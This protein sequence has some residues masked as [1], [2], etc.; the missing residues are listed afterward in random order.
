MARKAHLTSTIVL[1]AALGC[2]A[3][4]APKT[5]AA[6]QSE[7]TFDA[8]L[9]RRMARADAYAKSRPGMA[10]IVLRDRE[11]GA[12]WRTADA[13]THVW[14]CSTPKLAIAVDLL[15]RS[16]QGRITLTAQDRAQMHDMLHSSDNDAAHALWNRYGGEAE[17]GKRFPLY[18]MTDMTFTAEHPHHWGW[19]R[20]TANDLDRLMN[21]VLTRMPHEDRDYL[22]REMR[23]VDANQQWGV[24]GAG[25]AAKPGNKNGWADDNDDG[26]WIMNSVGF[27]GPR[28]RFTLA[29]MNDTRVIEG[30]FDVGRTTTTE[31]S[32]ILF[33]G[34]FD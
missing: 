23:T 16:D 33:E 10:G 28:A 17:F 5:A 32:R 9:G 20:T 19:I 14:A 1:L 25:A 26:S 4:G 34:Y 3:T 12:V 7:A 30:G 18:G 6:V 29:I 11:T 24:W 8:E 31:I 15:L 13:Q 2:S 21:F 27:A 22:V